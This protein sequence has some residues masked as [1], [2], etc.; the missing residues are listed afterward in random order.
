[1]STISSSHCWESEPVPNHETTMTEAQSETLAPS[2]EAD[3]R[4]SVGEYL[5]AMS[6]EIRAPLNAV[7]GMSGL[8]LDGDLT[9]KNKQYAR[10]VHSAGESLAA[11]L[12]DLIDLSRVSADRLAIEPI[13][14]DLKS[15]VEETAS[16]LSPRAGE[17]GLVLRVDWRPELPRHVIGDPGRARQVLGNLAGHAVNGT[18]H[19]EVVIRVLPDGERDGVPL[20]RFMVDDT[21]IGITPERL[22][23]VFDNYVPVDASPY[24]SFGVTGLGLRLSADLVRR[25][26]GE[27]GAESEAG[28]GSRFWFVLPMPSADPVEALNLDRPKVGGRILVAEPDPAAQNRYRAQV[29][30][31]GWAASFIDDSSRLAEV[32]HAAQRAGEPYH[33]C[34]ISDYAVRPLHIDL[35][36]RLKAEP[37]LAKVAL[38]MVTAVGSPGEGKKLWHAGFAA[39]LR[40]PVPIEEIRDTLTTLHHLGPDG[41]GPSLITRHSL[42]EVR[43]AQVFAPEGIDEMLASLTPAEDDPPPT[44]AATE[45]PAPVSTS[46]LPIFGAVPMRLADAPVPRSPD[47]TPVAELTSGIDS[48][49][50]QD[51]TNVAVLEELAPLPE[52]TLAL[53]EPPTMV[54]PAAT[55]VEPPTV[56]EAPVIP[57][58]SLVLTE[59][60]VTTAEPSAAIEGTAA[61]PSIGTEASAGPL[62]D[63][64]GLVAAE[65]P[66]PTNEA[67]DAPDLWM[68]DVVADAAPEVT[69]ESSPADR[70]AADPVATKEPIAIEIDMAELIEP[71]PGLL[72]HATEAIVDSVEPFALLDTIEHMRTTTKVEP[73]EAVEGFALERDEEWSAPADQVAPIEGFDRT[74]LAEDT[75]DFDVDVVSDVLPPGAPISEAEL[76]HTMP[77]DGEPT[78]P[79]HEADTAEGTD[80]DS[81]EPS[82]NF[83]I[84]LLP[85][86]DDEADEAPIEIN[87]IEAPAVPELGAM[88]VIVP[89]ERA[90]AN[91]PVAVEAQAEVIDEVQTF[92]VV[93]P[94]FIDSVTRGGGFFVQHIISAFVRETSVAVTDLASAVNRGDGARI[95]EALRAI[96][97]STNSVGAARLADLVGRMEAAVD[98][99][100]IDEA[101]GQIGSIE[102]AFL[103]VRTALDTAAPTGLPAEV[104]AVGAAFLDQLGPEKDGPTKALSIKLADTFLTDGAQ[105]LVELRD[106]VS[107]GQADQAQRIAQTVKGMCGLITADSLG[108]LCALVEADARL[109]RVAQAERY[110]DYLE[111]EFDRVRQAL[112]RARG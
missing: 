8:L 74:G 56:A 84:P 97:R 89:A 60:V 105:R 58:E 54:E 26:G 3:R 102:H 13:A 91:V 23:H 81:A 99:E 65:A 39:Y 51:A 59:A 35:A 1:M 95:K 103:E 109:K 32:L 49:V 63:E 31:S 42:A 22:A 4:P 34:V 28:K 80:A 5:L 37:G 100:R 17:R 64:A 57:I 48:D 30:A 70:T 73:L 47:A 7:I 36:N 77:L 52:P 55:S 20:V 11:I 93:A 6:H 87:S 96:R 94:E 2:N 69:E 75:I 83:A 12:N 71:A 50:D 21:G 82:I 44:P 38:V 90:V 110:L 66:Q 9:E 29:E 104:S 68:I 108:K 16:V 43:N 62:T 112:A 25:M 46:Y 27:I 106:A 40:K 41:R 72:G 88:S 79:G 45:T 14:F 85:P 53:P 10:S 78:S 101:A 86:A 15:M 92:D 18:S 107:A 19:G 76:T 24:R 61:E 98:A 33:A 67:A 111:R